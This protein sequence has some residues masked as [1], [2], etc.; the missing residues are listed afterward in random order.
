L[1]GE[2]YFKL[3]DCI[4]HVFIR[5]ANPRLSALLQNL[6][7]RKD[8]KWQKHNAMIDG[9]KKIKDIQNDIAY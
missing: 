2:E 8:N 5:K 1:S 7:E 4:N 6:V 3:L 9:P